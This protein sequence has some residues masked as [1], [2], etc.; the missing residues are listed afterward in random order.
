MIFLYK[1]APGKHNL[2]IFFKRNGTLN[3]W[4]Y[5]FTQPKYF[6]TALKSTKV[7]VEYKLQ[8]EKKAVRRW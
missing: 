3:T 8:R 7:L 1:A 4:T 6:L 5:L 2:F